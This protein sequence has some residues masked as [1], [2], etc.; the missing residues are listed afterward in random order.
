MGNHN[1]VMLMDYLAILG[2][3]RDARGKRYEWLYLL[4]VTTAA[5]LTGDQTYADMAA[6]AKRHK[7]ARIHWLRPKRKQVPSESTIRRTV[8]RLDITLLEESTIFSARKAFSAS[9]LPGQWRRCWR[10]N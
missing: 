9:S 4:T 3:P 8:V 7:D 5:M 2:D 6:W 10:P 1:Y